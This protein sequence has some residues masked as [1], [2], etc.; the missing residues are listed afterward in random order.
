M[1]EGAKNRDG[2]DKTHI[3]QIRMPRRL[4]TNFQSLCKQSDATPSEVVR[5]MIRSVVRESRNLDEML[6][7]HEQNIRSR[8]KSPSEIGSTEAANLKKDLWEEAPNN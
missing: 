5:E 1:S 6:N 3:M 4:W 7:E 8:M 2:E